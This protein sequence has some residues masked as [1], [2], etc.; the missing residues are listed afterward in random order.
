MRA[1]AQAQP[2][3]ARRGQLGR[4]Q[5]F[6][7][8]G[9]ARL[10]ASSSARPRG[11]GRAIAQAAPFLPRPLRALAGAL[12]MALDASCICLPA[13]AVACLVPTLPCVPAVLPPSV[14]LIE[15]AALTPLVCCFF[16]SPAAA[17]CAVSA[18]HLTEWDE[19]D[20]K[21]V[22]AD[23]DTL[24]AGDDGSFL[25]GDDVYNPLPLMQAAALAAADAALR[26]EQPRQQP[27]DA[28]GTVALGSATAP[29]EPQAPPPPPVQLA[30]APGL[31]EE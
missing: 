9:E 14:W 24:I 13:V 19:E 15:F 3:R 25:Y 28:A 29:E 20:G 5:K 4:V 31:K 7:R 26:D 8:L 18:R 10:R 23:D 16:W 6:G 12:G 22:G 2:L 21:F 1:Q 11:A 17:A 30:G 27:R